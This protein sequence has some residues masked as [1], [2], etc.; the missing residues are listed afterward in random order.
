MEVTVSRTYIVR[1]CND[2]LYFNE[3][4]DR[5]VCHDSFD[6]PN[7]DWECRHP[8]GTKSL[9]G[10]YSRN[11]ECEIPEWCPEKGGVE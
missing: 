4:E 9:G 11:A 7:Y 1:K 3:T 8:K 5:S 6:E 10:S 2:C